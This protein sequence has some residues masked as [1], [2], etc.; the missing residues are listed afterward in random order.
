MVGTFRRVDEAAEGRNFC[1]IVRLGVGADVIGVRRIARRVS[2]GGPN[3]WR[4]DWF[5]F[6]R[7]VAFGG[8]LDVDIAEGD[9]AC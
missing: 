7:I 2:A 6:V 3:D 1:G 5:K 8:G 9:G 4:A